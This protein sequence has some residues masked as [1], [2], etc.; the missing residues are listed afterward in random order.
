[1]Q[2][3]NKFVFIAIVFAVMATIGPIDIAAQGGRAEPTEIRFARGS[4][5][6]TLTGTLSNGQEMEYRFTA[7]A[8]QTVTI[9]NPTNAI[10]D[11][12]IFSLENDVETEFDSSRTFSIDLPSDG[13]YLLF[14]RKKVAGPLRAKYS[15]RIGIK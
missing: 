5:S 10:F 2:R 7:R 15:V 1:M 12:R 13:E 14:I 11:V 9:T 4:S 6:A 3:L 8:G